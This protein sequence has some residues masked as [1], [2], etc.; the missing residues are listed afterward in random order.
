M[1]RLPSELPAPPPTAAPTQRI[2]LLA[3]ARELGVPADYGRRRA[4][5]ATREPAHLAFAGYDIH[6]RPQW[7]TPR[8]A[9]AWLR[10]RHAAA[11]G[12]IELQLVS[13]F[14]SI[15]YQVGIIER[16]LARGQDMAQILAVSAA[17]GYSEHHT[18]RAIDLTTPG[19]A[20][21]EEEFEQSPAFRWLV[22]NAAEFGFSLSFPRGNR[23]GITY[24]PWHWCWRQ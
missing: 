12:Q 22:K 16:K 15:E 2:A 11:L 13:A 17:P 23:H 21:L 20:A 5:R 24:E 19:F 10:M 8:A 6:A 14:R 4:L 9:R 18:G 1:T 7:L 3:R